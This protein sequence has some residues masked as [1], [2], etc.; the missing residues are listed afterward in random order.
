MTTFYQSDPHQ[1]AIRLNSAEDQE[2]YQSIGMR[3]DAAMRRLPAKFILREVL[4]K[5]IS[6]GVVCAGPELLRLLSEIVAQTTRGLGHSDIDWTQT[7]WSPIVGCDKFSLG[8]LLCYAQQF[9][10]AKHAQ[11]IK[12][13]GFFPNGNPMPRQ[14]AFPFEHVQI[15]PDRFGAPLFTRKPKRVFVNAFSDVFHEDVPLDVIQKMHLVMGAAPQHSFQVLTKRTERMAEVAGK[16]PWYDNIWMGAT[17]E[18]RAALH[19]IDALRS[20]P[21]RVR[22]LSIEPLLEDLGDLNLKGI[23]WVVVGGESGRKDQEVRPMHPD[24]VR[25]IRH[26]CAVY[27]VPFFFKQA[28]D[29]IHE[30]QIEFNG[31][32]SATLRTAPWFDWLDGTRSYRVHKRVSGHLF[33]GLVYREYP[34]GLDLRSKDVGE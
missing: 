30:H 12:G 6:A 3:I 2:A 22:W 26:Q 24:W 8:C 5:A 18:N 34:E 21:A 27:G 33:D 11:Y 20:I 32:C 31:I 10:N 28:G 14:Y 19:R 15:F 4:P 9:H 1:E 13:N 29:W 17:V 16:L 23:H 25:R 7:G